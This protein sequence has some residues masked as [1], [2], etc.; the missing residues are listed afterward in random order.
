NTTCT[1]LEASLAGDEDPRNRPKETGDYATHCSV[2]SDT[3]TRLEGTFVSV[4][5]VVEAEEDQD[6]DNRG[7]LYDHLAAETRLE[8]YAHELAYLPDL[9]EASPTP[10]YSASNVQDEYTSNKQSR[11]VIMLQRHERIMIASGNT[12]PPPAYE[13]VCGID[14]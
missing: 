5:R 7:A 9:N 13:T 3:V 14:V 1:S 6:S 11:L 2:E 10:L 8:D 4:I 12:L